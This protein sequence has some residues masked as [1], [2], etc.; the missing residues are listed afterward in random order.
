[1]L[2]CPRCGTQVGEAASFCPNCGVSLTEQPVISSSKLVSS[3][4]RYFS[5]SYVYCIILSAIL[6][7]SILIIGGSIG[8]QVTIDQAQQIIM[9]LE[10][11]FGNWT[12]LDIFSSNLG[13][14]FISFIPVIGSGWMLLVQYNTGYMFGIIAKAYEINFIS[15]T[16]LTIVGPTGLLEYSAYIL[17]LSESFIIVYSALKRDLKKRLSKQTWK[18]LLIVIVLLFIGGIVEAVSVGL[19]II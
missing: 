13:I 4:K 7:F 1:M 12:A 19:P 18:T 6:I 3:F 5:R 17:T 10:R 14:T 8:E 9:E 2:F 11:D 15:L 16:V